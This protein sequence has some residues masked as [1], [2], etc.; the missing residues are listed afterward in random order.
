[1]GGREFGGIDQEDGS[2]RELAPEPD[3]RLGGP[4]GHAI[5]PHFF[6]F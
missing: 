1:V 2:Q 3:R 6:F 5:I 4:E